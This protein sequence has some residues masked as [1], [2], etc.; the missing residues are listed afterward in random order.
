MTIGDRDLRL[1][2]LTCPLKG[3]IMRRLCCYSCEDILRNAQVR[4]C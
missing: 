2:D 4:E 1:F 3:A